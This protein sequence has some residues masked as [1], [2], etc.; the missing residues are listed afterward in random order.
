MYEK[1]KKLRTF[2][3]LN[4]FKAIVYV[5]EVLWYAFIYSIIIIF[6]DNVWQNFVI[7]FLFLI[8]LLTLQFFCVSLCN[9][10]KS[11]NVRFLQ[12]FHMDHSL[13]SCVVSST[14]HCAPPLGLKWLVFMRSLVSLQGFVGQYL[15]K[16]CFWHHVL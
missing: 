12:D 11:W 14:L 7:E 16:M 15:G 9:F 4:H 13:W 5:L 3:L 6:K 10:A 2:F 1:H 8:E